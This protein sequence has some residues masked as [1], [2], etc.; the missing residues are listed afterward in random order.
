V[1]SRVTFAVVPPAMLLAIWWDD[2]IDRITRVKYILYMVLGFGLAIVPMLAL[3]MRAPD[4]FIF[5]TFRYPFLNLKWRTSIGDA[6]G[7]NFAKWSFI[8]RQILPQPANLALIAGFAATLVSHRARRNAAYPFR[9]EIR[10]LLL[11]SIALSVAS[12]VPSPTFLPYYYAPVPFILLAALYCAASQEARLPAWRRGFIGA[13]FLSLPV[14]IGFYAVE[15]RDLTRKPWVPFAQHA[16][17]EIVARRAAGKPV[18]TLLP[19]YAMEG[20]AA[21][22]PHFAT[23]PFA[24]RVSSMLADEQCERFRM[25]NA[26]SLEQLSIANPP[27]LVLLSDDTLAESPL[28]EYAGA[29]GTPVLALD[30]KG[31]PLVTT[32]PAA[33]D[34]VSR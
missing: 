26:K 14:A 20:G 28:A 4:A 6:S 3:A 24:F 11:I 12:L 23:G 31:N 30:P 25:P 13:A 18:L 22:Y 16:V 27:G 33:R 10:T 2:R 34:T 17:G 5:D 8:I 1:G 29:H 21:V 7:T 15:L 32:A 9:W 19:A